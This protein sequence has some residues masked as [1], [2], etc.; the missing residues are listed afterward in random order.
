MKTKLLV[1]TLAMLALVAGCGVGS[2]TMPNPGSG[3]LKILVF[4]DQS[5]EPTTNT[6]Q[7]LPLLAQNKSAI[8]ALAPL[9][10]K[11]MPD[12]SVRDLSVNGLKSWAK[13]HGIA[14]MPLVVNYGGTGQFLLSASARSTAV[15]QLASIL[16]RENYAGLNIDFELLKPDARDGLTLLMQSLYTQVHAM[17]KQ[18]SVDVIPSGTTRKANTGVYNYPALA[19]ASNEIVLMTYDDHDSGSAP[20]PIAPLA[21]V[22]QRVNEALRIGVPPQKLIV[23]LADYGYDWPA[24]STKAAT[25]PLSTIEQW[26]TSGKARISRLADGSPHFTY[27]VNGVVHTVWYEDG[28]AIVPIVQLARSKDVEGLALWLGGYETTN[29]WKALR[30][31]AGTGPSTT[32]I[33]AGSK[34]SASAIPKPSSAARPGRVGGSS[35][36]SGSKAGSS[37]A[38]SSAA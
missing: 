23:G 9:W 12:G 26:I 14:L 28:V 16:K 1:A 22:T 11:V 17:G 36:A 7:I 33:R 6:A 30:G 25:L 15:S 4:Y 10:Y 35:T 13:S 32:T 31:A 5:A 27:S 2:R 18:L 37:K 24:G 29:Y 38:S 8:S 21:W 20:G 19:K 3:P 34:S